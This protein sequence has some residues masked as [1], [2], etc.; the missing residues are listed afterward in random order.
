VSLVAVFIPLLL[1]GGIVGRLF[2]EFSVSLSVAIV[3]SMLISLTVTPMLASVLLRAPTEV[4]EGNEHPDSRFHRFYDRTLG[5]VIDHSI[6][7][8]LV[9]VLVI[10]LAGVLYV[11]V[12]KGFFPQEDTGRLQGSIIAAQSISYGAMQK[13]FT[14]INH[15]VMQNPNVETAAG[16]V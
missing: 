5:W 14:A 12:P 2:R 16:F 11:L 10:V 8:G 3:I 6:L 15:K 1:M 13:D 9:T 7:M 4:H